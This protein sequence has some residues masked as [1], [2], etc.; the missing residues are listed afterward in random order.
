MCVKERNRLATQ[1]KERERLEPGY[2]EYEA[3]EREKEVK[4]TQRAIKHVLTE[5]YYAWT[6]AR[7]IGAKD[8]EVDLSGEGIAYTPMEYLEDALETEDEVEGTKK[9]KKEYV[10]EDWV[11][12]KKK[13]E[14]PKV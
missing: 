14:V 12:D 9:D 13:D 6:E 4:Q 7:E 10:T 5:R 11:D 8:P 3:E 2:G 1:R